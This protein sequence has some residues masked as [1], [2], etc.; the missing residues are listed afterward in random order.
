MS[1]GGFL[2]SGLSTIGTISSVGERDYFT[3]ALINGLTYSARVAGSSTG[4][5]TLYDPVFELRNNAGALLGSNDDY[6][7]AG[8]DAQFTFRAG[9]TATY[10]LW[11]SDTTGHTGSYRMSL[12]AGY[13]SNASDSVV[14]TAL[15]DAIVGMAGNDSIWGQGGDDRIWGGADSDQLVGGDGNDLLSGGLGYDQIWGQNGND[16]IMGDAG[17]DRLSGGLGADRFVYNSVSDGGDLIFGSDGAAAMEGLGVAGGDVIDVRAID[18]NPYLANDQAFTVGT[19]TAGAGSIGKMW[20]S[21]EANGDTLLYFSTDT[22]VAAEMTIRIRDGYGV[23][24][25]N[26]YANL[27]ILM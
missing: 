9:A 5:G 12:S 4:Q 26:Y 15:G 21:N 6:P 7:G 14:G 10:Q 13:A 18:A 24:V 1:Y 27:D 8:L 20:G 19:P 2:G 16:V 3:T 22:D 11:A 25:S 17:G 23:Q